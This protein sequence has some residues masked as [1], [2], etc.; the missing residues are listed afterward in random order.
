MFH[1]TVKTSQNQK[2]NLIR[3]RS[4]YRQGLVT[5]VGS[6]HIGEW[7]FVTNRKFIN[8][9]CSFDSAVVFQ[10]VDFCYKALLTVLPTY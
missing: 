4:I 3:T 9:P 5:H 7:G 8:F 6:P 10:Q 2:I 1:E